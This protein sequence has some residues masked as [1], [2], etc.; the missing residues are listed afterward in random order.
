MAKKKKKL[1]TI[2]TTTIEPALAWNLPVS[3][4]EHRRA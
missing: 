3:A 1:R 2:T 4:E